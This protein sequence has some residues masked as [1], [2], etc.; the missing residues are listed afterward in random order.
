MLKVAVI[1]LKP[2]RMNLLALVETPVDA[3]TQPER[4]SGY[5]QRPIR[6]HL[7]HLILIGITIYGPWQIAQI[8]NQSRG[9]VVPPDFAIA[10]KTVVKPVLSQK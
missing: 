7:R 8:C 5:R 2:K 3:I 6:I 9:T 10:G 4:Q 1:K